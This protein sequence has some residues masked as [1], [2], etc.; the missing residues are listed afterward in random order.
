[1]PKNLHAGISTIL[2][3]AVLF[4]WE[5]LGPGAGD[6]SAQTNGSAEGTWVGALDVGV[7]SLR[8]VVHVQQTADGAHTA[9]IDSPDQG[10]TGIPVADVT[11][12]DGT[13]ILE[14]PSIGARYEGSIAGDE[15]D[16]TW[17]QGGRSLPLT[18]QRGEAPVVRRPQ[19]PTG[20]LPYDTR[21]V[22]FRNEPDGIEL[23]GTLTIPRLPG[24]Y[25]AAVL[26]SGSGP[27]DRDE[28]AF[29][30]RP[31]LVLSDYLTRQGIAVLRYDDRGVGGS[32]GDFGAATTE[33][34][35]RDAR[36][37]VAYLRGLDDVRFSQI[38][39]VGHSEGG[40]VAPIAARTAPGEVAFLV[41]IAAPGIDGEQILFLQDSL[42]AA[43]GGATPDEIARSRERK[44]L[45]FDVLKSA[46]DRE[47][48]S[49]ALEEAMRG[50]VLTDQEQSELREAG[51]SIDDL[52]AQ[53]I[54][55]INSPWF[56]FF[57]TYDPLPALREIEV[58]VLAIT[59]EKDLQVP[60]GENLPPIE[61]ALAKGR[62]KR[63]LVREVR[64]LNHLMQTA[65]TGIPRE[66]STIEETFAPV[67]LQLIG[68]WIRQEMEL[69]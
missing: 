32:T 16:G 63:F 5:A 11:A 61:E 36:A 35:A 45:I 33:D 57:L 28:T 54:Q 23:A 69:E 48:A 31:F 41:L 37:A 30:H 68:N 1:M 20:P 7:M 24:P 56:R 51:I 44:A 14:V 47:D 15:I 18:L 3:V 9:T 55:Q 6:A 26:I 8:V 17:L 50:L 60:P 29:G 62:S 49:R 58:P 21:E 27:Q 42:I 64:G 59:G 67:A 12:T 10:A 22:R 19:E 52:I 25:P 46:P 66:Y 43:A 4:C 13:L 34:F 2:F 39:L 38:G 65:E 40:L 53:Q